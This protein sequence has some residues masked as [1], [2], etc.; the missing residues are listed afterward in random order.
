MM[1]AC[2][3]GFWEVRSLQGLS[4]VCEG[5]LSVVQGMYRVFALDCR[6]K[7]ASSRGCSV[8]KPL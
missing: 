8:H 1:R 7:H 6:S 3:G 2:C 5:L 4:R